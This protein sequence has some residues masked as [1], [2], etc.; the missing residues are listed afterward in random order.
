MDVFGSGCVP[1]ENVLYVNFFD[2]MRHDRHAG[3][4]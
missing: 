3:G 1:A 2:G 4:E